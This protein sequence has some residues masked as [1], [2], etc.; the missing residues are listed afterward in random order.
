MELYSVSVECVNLS[1]ARLLR[2]GLFCFF[3]R[4]AKIF[5]N[6]CPSTKKRRPQVGSDKTNLRTVH[7]RT[8]KCI[9][10]IRNTNHFINPGKDD[11][12]ACFFIF[13]EIPKYS[14]PF[15]GS[16]RPFASRKG[17]QSERKTVLDRKGRFI[18]SRSEKI[19]GIVVLLVGL[20]LAGSGIIVSHNPA[21]P[22]F[23]PG[24]LMML[25]FANIC[26]ALINLM[27][28]KD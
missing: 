22:Q 4:Q 15:S 3:N 14:G 16:D 5:K 10:S 8:F 21:H 17:G 27:P 9:C 13:S 20:A 28:D 6:S 25:G 23:L 7:I 18:M 12:Q 19:I 2:A 26:F 11:K 1:F 24:S